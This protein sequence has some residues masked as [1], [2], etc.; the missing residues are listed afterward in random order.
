M[1]A[2]AK[3]AAPQIPALLLQVKAARRAAVPI[4]AITTPDPAATIQS[5][6]DAINGSAP[7][8]VWDVV[9]G[10]KALNDQAREVI[11]KIIGSEFDPTIG[12]PTALLTVIRKLPPKSLVFMQLAHRFLDNAGNVQAAWNL[13]DVFKRDGR[14]LIMLA[15]SIDLP[16]ELAGDVIVLDEPLRELQRAYAELREKASEQL[17][18]LFNPDDYPNSIQGEFSLDWDFPSIEPPAYLKNIH[19]DLYEQECQRIRGRF[20]EAVRLAE[21]AFVAKFHELVSH[22]ADRLK[23]DVDGKPKVFRDSA[24]ENLNAFFSE[25]KSLDVGSNGELQQLVNKAQDAVNG[26]TASDLREDDNTR[27]DVG[28]KLA[29]IGLTLDSM[30][31]NKPKRAIDLDGE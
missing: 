27:N 6:S 4:V 18:D 13:R 29:E 10:V 12:N 5:V 28:A 25:F 2:K 24:I 16:A 19:P 30:M 20:E 9:E 1:S 15:P 8:L 7:H 11:P 31:V 21:Q 23:G 22:L 26:I 3:A 14:M 17:G